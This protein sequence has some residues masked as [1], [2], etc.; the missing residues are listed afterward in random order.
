MKTI[1]SSLQR[2]EKIVNPLGNRQS[3]GSAPKREAMALN[4]KALKLRADRKDGKGQYRIGFENVFDAGIEKIRLYCR[5]CGTMARDKDNDCRICK[6]SFRRDSSISIAFQAKNQDLIL[7]VMLSDDKF[8]LSCIDC[9]LPFYIKDRLKIN[10]KTKWQT[11]KI[12]SGEVRYKV[13]FDSPNIKCN[14]LETIND[15]RK[16][17]RSLEVCQCFADRKKKYASDLKRDRKARKLREL[18]KLKPQTL[19]V[20]KTLKAEFDALKSLDLTKL[21]K[22]E[23]RA[24]MQRKI[25]LSKK[26]GLNF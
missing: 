18:D 24:K 10:E 22:V 13:N 5:N 4:H 12:K 3:G 7:P 15:L 8:S 23:R 16:I 21:S 14:E 20:D 2:F 17:D 11:K 19:K 1:S 9:Q 6:T 26:L 25:Q